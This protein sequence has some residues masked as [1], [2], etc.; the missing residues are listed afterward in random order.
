MIITL[1]GAPGSG[2]STVAKLLAQKLGY[3]HYSTGDFMRELAH[4]RHI[5]V[6][7]INELAKTDAS[8]DRT[9][10]QRQIQLG[11]TEDNFVIDGR[12]SFHFIPHS[13]KVFIDVDV[14]EAAQRILKD[15]LSGLRK[16]EHSQ[17]INEMVQQIEQ[18]KQAERARYQKYYHL[19]I[20]DPKNYDL[21][22]D[23][24]KIPPDQVVKKI[25][26]H[27]QL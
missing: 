25:I 22:I 18:R 14:K 23:S 26:A 21:I 3:K 1:S 15:V 17:S 27:F 9:L 5:T 12:L 2:K 4:Q 6:L 10:D 20:D 24:T 7:E 16:E 8:I 13:K 19:N 11:K